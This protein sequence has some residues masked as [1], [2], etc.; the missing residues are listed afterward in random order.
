MVNKLRFFLLCGLLSCLGWA[1]RAQG[2]DDLKRAKPTQLNAKLQAAVDKNDARELAK[3]LKSKPEFKEDGSRMGKNDKGGPL[4]IPLLYDVVDRTL[5]GETSVELCKVALDAGCDIY[6]IFNGKTPIY[7]IMDYLATTP[8][9][10]TG[11]GMELLDLFLG[12]SGFDINRRY[13]SL[14]P[15]FSYLLSTNF[16]YLGGKYDKDYL[17]TP[18]LK[19]LIDNG[20]RLNT[21]DEN[22]ASLLLLASSTNN[23]Y[24]QNYLLDNGV[25]I[26]KTA[27]TQGNN[28]IYAAIKSNDIEVLQK[29][30]AN[31]QIKLL[32]ADVKEET[33]SVSPA[34]YNFLASECARNADTYNELVDFRGHF[35]DKKDLVQ[36]K[37]ENL[38]RNETNAASDF[39][40]IYTVMRRYPDLE[41]ITNPKLRSIYRQDA[42]SI[43]GYYNSALS[44]AMDDNSG[45]DLNAD[46]RKNLSNFVTYYSQRV[47]FDPDDK[48]DKAVNT[49]EFLS[50]CSGLRMVVLDKYYDRENLI[51]SALLDR[52]YAF[53]SR[54]AARDTST[55]GSALRVVRRK[56]YSSSVFKPFYQKHYSS[57]EE[58]ES[59]LYASINRSI[60]FVN[61]ENARAR[62]EAARNRS[63]ASSSSSS[64]SR[65]SSSSRSE[66]SSSSSEKTYT[67]R[68]HLYFEDGDE[69]YESKIT[70]FFKGFLNTSHKDFYT[71]THGYV[72]L[73][74]SDGYGD[75]IDSIALSRNILFHDSYSIE[76]LEIVDGGRYEI[77]IDC[78]R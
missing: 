62:A 50:V 61:T 65:E 2:F 55:I 69:P 11:V 17:S 16:N 24:L 53:L 57:L 6:S 3:L 10:Q 66:E 78:R 47:H 56:A 32:T 64:S 9:A 58:K 67:A 23:D 68:V 13:R 33:A 30:I 49:L 26:Y 28:A 40:A 34:M 76:D 8:S 70:V 21:Y 46:S 43:D 77:C 29:I 63:Y 20:A 42:A 38:A 22:G 60:D 5:N 25:N 45:F 59:K 48:I 71:D 74:W 31:Y 19:K 14:P 36:S 35:T 54:L 72:T 4:V 52:R 37:Y 41:I 51:A 18:L 73:T 39:I 7:R 27:D 44:A 15:P 75:T 12:K 1:A